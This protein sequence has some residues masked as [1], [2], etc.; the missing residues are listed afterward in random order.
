MAVSRTVL[1]ENSV[2]A[3]IISPEIPPVATVKPGEV[4]K[5]VD[6]NFS[7]SELNPCL[8]FVLGF[9]DRVRR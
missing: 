5:R 2:F 8:S 7:R 9:Q 3:R 6:Q 4:I 1:S